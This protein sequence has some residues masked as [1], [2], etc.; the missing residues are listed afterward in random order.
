MVEMFFIPKARLPFLIQMP[1]P[2]NDKTV[3]IQ[4]NDEVKRWC[5]ANFRATYEFSHDG[6]S[7]LGA[8][9]SRN[10]SAYWED[11]F[12]IICQ[13]ANDAVHFKMRWL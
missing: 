5:T 9:M 7:T 6:I 10:W 13:D 11:E 1:D 12:F 2:L 8:R 4:L 3:V